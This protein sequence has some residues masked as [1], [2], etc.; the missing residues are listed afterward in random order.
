MHRSIFLAQ[1]VSQCVYDLEM[2]EVSCPFKQA[3][4]LEYQHTHTPKEEVRQGG[5]IALGFYY[6]QSNSSLENDDT[7]LAPG[8]LRGRN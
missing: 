7:K 8:V 5:S 6:V 2:D 4:V 3:I 1:K